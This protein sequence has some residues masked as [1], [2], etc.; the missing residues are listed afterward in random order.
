M[1]NDA[2]QL[3]SMLSAA[4][5]ASPS[6]DLVLPAVHPGTREADTATWVWIMGFAL[7]A[8]V[9][10]VVAGV[11]RWR[12]ER[13]RP[14]EAAF[15]SLARRLGLSPAD[16]VLVRKLASIIEAK[17]VALLISETAFDRAASAPCRAEATGETDEN[18]VR[19]VRARLFE[20]TD[21][22]SA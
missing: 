2:R 17:P 1:V 8:G 18:R 19:M 11:A 6:S 7:L 12:L 4:A 9:P 3:L 20:S 5:L 10:G 15:R 14:E 16:R 13:L 22:L 21:T